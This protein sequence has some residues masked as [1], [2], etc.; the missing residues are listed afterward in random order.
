MLLWKGGAGA[1]SAVG[2][3]RGGGVG[4]RVDLVEGEDV[5]ADAPAA[6]DDFVDEDHGV[7]AGGLT[8][9]LGVEVGNAVD[10]VFLLFDGEPAGTFR[11]ANGIV[12]FSS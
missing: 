10:E 12:V 8:E 5:A 7:A 9:D 3:A 11:L 1:R 4:F 6:V 2:D